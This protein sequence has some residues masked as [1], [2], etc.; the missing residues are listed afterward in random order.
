MSR[1]SWTPIPP[2]TP[3]FQDLVAAA[4]S[5]I[6]WLHRGGLSTMR[7]AFPEVLWNGETDER[8]VALSYDDGPDPADAPQLLDVLE[9]QQVA[10]S[11][12]WFGY[13]AARHPAIVRAAAE[14]G[15]LIGTHGF[16][17]RSFILE[18]RATLRRQ[19]AVT[20]QL[21]AAAAGRPAEAIRDIR[22]PY[23]VFTPDLLADLAAWGFRAVVGSVIP[24]HWKQPQRTSVEQVLRQVG[25]GAL[26]VLHESHGGPPVAQLTEE[27]IVRLR[28]E[29]YRFV[30]HERL[31]ETLGR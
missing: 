7:L 24:I 26:I 22:P 20:R 31:W 2:D 6:E 27:L 21:L 1:S 4:A 3:D 23:G 18:D 13:G 15:H 8:I 25:P 29:G 5:R 30:T 16:D 11:F 19:L 28:S 14:A 12:C 10:A 17:H 9:R